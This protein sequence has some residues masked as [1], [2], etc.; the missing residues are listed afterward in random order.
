[1]TAPTLEQHKLEDGSI[2]LYDPAKIVVNHIPELSTRVKCKPYKFQHDKA[3]EIFYNLHGPPSKPCIMCEAPTGTGKTY[4]AG[5]YLDMVLSSQWLEGKT[6]SPWPMLYVTKATV[7][8]Q[9][10]RVL[11]LDFGISE[12]E[13]LVTNYDKL[14]STFG[15]QFLKEE[16]IIHEGEEHLVYKWHNNLQPSIVIWDEAHNLKNERSLQS[17]VQ[18][19]FCEVHTPLGPVKQIF[20]TATPFTAVIES[21]Y[22]VVACKMKVEL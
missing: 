13:V 6:F 9:T 10:Q 2:I 4:I 7:V 21:R 8:E 20:F 1:M 3:T 15:E 22:L 14:R 16:W 17:K 5:T 11:E 19:A 12:R 18:Q